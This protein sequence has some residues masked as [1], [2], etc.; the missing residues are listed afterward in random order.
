M[1]YEQNHPEHRRLR[2]ASKAL[3][4]SGV[5]LKWL[6]PHPFI[7]GTVGSTL[8]LAGAYWL[9]IILGFAVP[10]YTTLPLLSILIGCFFMVTALN[11]L[12]RSA[13]TEGFD[14]RCDH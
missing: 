6:R 10:W 14:D 3:R 12:S 11:H 1:R 13:G 5:T 4:R 9:L 2:S 8:F 7:A